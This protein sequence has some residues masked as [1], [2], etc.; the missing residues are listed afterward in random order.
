MQIHET[1][2]LFSDVQ[3]LPVFPD[4]KTF[5]DCFPKKDLETIVREYESEKG[6][7]NFDLKEFVYNNFTLPS[8][9]ESNFT[10]DLSRS[11]AEH[12]NAL[13]DF[14]MRTP[15]PGLNGSLIG[16][17]NAYIVPG[18]RF[19]EIYYWD[20]YFT[21]LGLRAGNR[22]DLIE[23]MVSNFAWLIDE[24]GHIPNGNRT[25]YLSRS[26][27]PFFSMMVELLSEIK[28]KDVLANYLPAM[29]KEYSFWMKGADSLTDAGASK[30][31]V[32]R[33]DDGNILN[34]YWDNNNTPRPEAFKEDLE[35]SHESNTPKHEL[36]RHIRAAAESG[37]DFSSRWFRETN[38]FGTIHTTELIPVDL[39]CLLWKTEL[40]LSEANQL[41]GNSK[42]AAQYKAAANK[43]KEAI[44]QYCW[45]QEKG[46]Y[47]D[48]D[49]V[50]KK[51][52]SHYTMAAA[53]PLFFQ[54]S[55]NEQALQV[56]KILAEKFLKPGGLVTTLE[57]TGQQ[58]DAPNG[59]APLQWIGYIACKNY[60]HNELATKVKSA[61]CTTNEKVFQATGKMMEKYNV[62]G[63]GEAGGGGEYPNQDGFGWTNGVYLAMQASS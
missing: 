10:S 38:S 30:D 37:W 7:Q 48:Y 32:V 56:C 24:A 29:E 25:Y 59:W 17:P 19:G 33:L 55:T 41:S 18:G 26:Q 3:L 54:L 23:N 60:Q 9:K 22:A 11:A 34:R 63:S 12:V 49:F 53:F 35:L 31:R 39:N 43:R 52:T 51:Q 20:S 47:F 27:P 40:I 6:S 45:S 58:W 50:E 5:P 4:S 14:L 1:G 46:F 13:W 2:S 8:A 15:E 36:F 61:W 44:D 57:Q 16:L 62:E 28:G 21:M 42:K